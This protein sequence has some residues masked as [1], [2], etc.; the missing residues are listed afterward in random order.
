L[1]IVLFCDF[2]GAVS[3]AIGKS[4]LLLYMCRDAKLL[5]RETTEEIMIEE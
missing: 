2:A 1:L 5:A 4:W 3:S